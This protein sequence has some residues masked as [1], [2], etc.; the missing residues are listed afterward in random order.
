MGSK[1]KIAAT[2]VCGGDPVLDCLLV[3]TAPSYIVLVA[4]GSIPP[5]KKVLPPTPPAKNCCNWHSCSYQYDTRH[6]LVEMQTTQ[7]NNAHDANGSC[8]AAATLYTPNRETSKMACVRT[9]WSQRWTL[10]PGGFGLGLAE[11]RYLAGGL[12]DGVQFLRLFQPCS[13]VRKMPG[14]DI[15]S[16][17]GSA[18]SINSSPR[19]ST[20]GTL[21]GSATSRHR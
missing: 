2:A 17:L 8:N 18:A 9:S 15:I 5:Y 13:E 20:R 6:E 12:A 19:L 14:E 1:A 16:T 21:L 10:T 7:Q 4:P 3:Y 11:W